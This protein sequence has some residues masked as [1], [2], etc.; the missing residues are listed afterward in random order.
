MYRSLGMF[1]ILLTILIFT[2][3][4]VIFKFFER[5]KVDN[6]QAIVVNYLVAS[7]CGML[8]PATNFNLSTAITSDYVIPAIVVGG[9]FIITFTLMAFSA[10]K[11]GFSITTV[12][13]KMSLIIPVLFGIF[14][15]QEQSNFIKLL[16]IILA[17]VAIYFTSTSGGRLT[18]NKKYLWVIALLFFGQGI[19]DSTFKY[20]QE[21]YVTPQQGSSFLSIIF[22]FAGILGLLYFFWRAVKGKS[23]FQ[24]KNIFW[25]ILLGVPNY[26]TLYFFLRALDSSGLESSDIFPTMNMGI[27]VL[28]T[29]VGLIF[30]SEK[31]TKTNWFGV[32]LALLAIGLITFSDNLLK[33]FS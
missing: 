4:L 16:G 26:F 21:Y 25:G 20:A 31:L 15:L 2:L 32:F 33:Q 24:A 7:C 27:I 30:F 22:L 12:A 14:Y 19:A 13:N 9:L 6:L 3:M 1:D 18:F 28:S 10:Q 29:L 11:L 17:L 23:K 5:F 8:D